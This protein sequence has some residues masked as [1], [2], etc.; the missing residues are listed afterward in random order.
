[1]K[2]GEYTKITRASEFYNEFWSLEKERIELL[3][4]LKINSKNLLLLS[5]KEESLQKDKGR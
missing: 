4:R 2:F 5:K 1:M 3:D